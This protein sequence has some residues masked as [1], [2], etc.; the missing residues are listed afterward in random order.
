MVENLDLVNLVV[1]KSGGLVG[2][3]GGEWYIIRGQFRSG[4]I[5]VPSGSLDEV[6]KRVLA[7]TPGL[8]L[9]LVKRGS[10]DLNKHGGR[11]RNSLLVVTSYWSRLAFQPARI[12]WGNA[13]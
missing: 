11:T 8:N 2:P 3:V 9:G 7:Y 1:A 4:W 12:F 13:T 6:F 5:R 10:L